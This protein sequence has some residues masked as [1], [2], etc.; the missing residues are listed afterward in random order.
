MEEGNMLVRLRKFVQGTEGTIAVLTALGLVAFL[1]FASLAIDMGHL[2]VVRNELQNV[3]DAAAMGGAGKLIKEVSGAPQRDKTA[4]HDAAMDV[5]QRQ[6]TLSGLP[7]VAPGD[8]NDATITYG[9]WDTYTGDPATAWTDS[10]AA[11]GSDANAVRVKIRRATGTAYGPVTNILAGILG[12]NTSEVSATGT[13]YQSFTLNTIFQRTS[14][15]PTL[16]FAL[17]YQALMKADNQDKSSWWAHLLG[18]REAIAAAPTTQITK[19]YKDIDSGL[20]DSTRVQMAGNSSGDFPDNTIK[21]I[22]KAG[23]ISVSSTKP[24]YFGSDD[25]RVTS[26]LSMPSAKK[27]DT[28]YAGSEYAWKGNLTAIFDSLKQA[29]DNKK[30]NGKWAV[31]LVVYVPKGSRSD[32]SNPWLWRLAQLFSFGPSPAYACKVYNPDI[33]IEGTVPATV[34]EVNYKENCTTTSDCDNSNNFKVTVNANS[35]I[36]LVK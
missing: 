35:Y 26:S 11:P 25:Y 33:T 1:G 15:T 19:T 12:F 21:R 31:N 27:G 36:K 8:R 7:T 29:Y 34:D 17:P 24:K 23:G 6:A 20:L 4:A 28:W 14:S 16:P 9:N 18:P 3:A 30:Q 32:L 2:Y 10:D 13:A 22:V 5:L